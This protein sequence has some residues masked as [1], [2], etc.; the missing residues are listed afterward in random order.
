MPATPDP[1]DRLADLA[2][3][4]A[5][6]LGEEATLAVDCVREVIRTTLAVAEDARDHAERAW[7]QA[8]AMGAEDAL[9]QLVPYL[10]PAAA[11]SLR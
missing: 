2:E 8:W 1:F 9:A 7:H 10:P 3:T 11:A 5:R 6:T 4:L